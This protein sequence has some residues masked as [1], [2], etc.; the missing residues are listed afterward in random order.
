MPPTS[1][2]PGEHLAKELS[3]LGLNA[4]ALARHLKV[5]TQPCYPNSKGTV[6]DGGFHSLKPGQ[7]DSP[8]PNFLLSRRQEDQLSGELRLLHRKL[9]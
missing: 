8:S 5:L 2:H 3:A 1:I 4:A 7:N 6:K 9:L